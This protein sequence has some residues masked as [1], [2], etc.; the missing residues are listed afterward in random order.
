MLPMASCNFLIRSGYGRYIEMA[1]AYWNVATQWFFESGVLRTA[2]YQ[3]PA[4]A[5]TVRLSQ[6]GALES[7]S[8]QIKLQPQT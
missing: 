5:G 6:V 4:F 1:L 2:T 7:S 3:C 8:L